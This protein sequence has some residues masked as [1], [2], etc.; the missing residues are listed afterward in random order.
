[1]DDRG[2]L[3]APDLRSHQPDG[4]HRP[5]GRPNPAGPIGRLCHL[6]RS[7]QQRR[8]KL[9]LCALTANRPRAVDRYI[10]YFGGASRRGLT[11][12]SPTAV[13][14]HRF[15]APVSARPSVER[16]VP[17]RAPGPPPIAG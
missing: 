14:H 6:L 9:Y 1:P 17:R 10:D 13:S 4:R 16:A 2:P 7:T 8:V 5:L 15:Y 11:P 12:L 3:A